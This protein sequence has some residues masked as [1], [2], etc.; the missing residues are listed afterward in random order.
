MRLAVPLAAL[1]GLA[2]FVSP[3]TARPV[4]GN[5]LQA[6][7][8]ADLESGRID[9]ETWLIQSFRYV[10]APERLAAH[11]APETRTLVR[12][13]TP[14]IVEYERAR[15]ELSAAAIAEIESYL[16]APSATLRASYISPA[17]LFSLTYDTAGANAVNA[18]DVA[19]ANGVPDYVERCATYMDES[20]AEEITTLGFTAPALPGDG[21]YDV[22]FESMGAYG[23]TTTSGITTRI[24]LHNTF[25]GFPPNTDP[26]GNQLGAA[27]VTCAHEFKHASQFTTSGWSEGGWVELDAT[28]AEDI[29]YPATNDYWNYTNTN[30][31][32]VLGQPWTPLDDG[33]S[34]SYE[35]CLW[36]TYLSS[37]HGNALVVDFWDLRDLNPG[38]TVKKTYGDA[39]AL[40]GTNWDDSYAGFLEWSWFTGSRSEP[41]FGFPDAPNLKRMNLRGAAVAA[42]PFA[43]ADSVNQLAGHP[44]RFNPGTATG[45]PRVQFDGV[46]AHTNFTVS[47]ILKELAGAFTI[48]R[49]PVGAGNV[50]DYTSPLPWSALEYVGVIVANTK[51]SGGNQH[52]DLDVLDEP[53][54][55]AAPLVASLPDRLRQ[56]VPAPNP[57]AG[58]TTLRFALPRAGRATVRILD[59]AGRVIRTLVDG[60]RPAGANE[61]RWDGRDAAGRPVAAGIY[62]SRVEFGAERNHEKITLLR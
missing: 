36:E 14:V 38:D 43:V 45:A 28:W 61:V 5:S 16:A 6:A 23:Y 32:S 62:W 50:V 13:F 3:V 39:L 20:W 53:T 21:T 47:V 56:D 42:Y 40:Y 18:T 12:C 51:R 58:A 60:S 55:V 7:L 22:A 15:P 30:G 35:D 46:D 27:K 52:Y 54:A 26:D 10:F 29:V 37:L 31:A 59:V 19:P 9:R 8:V 44:W 4:D 24:V 49:P 48:V 33:G 34:G 1:A 2:V 41:A 17:G 57:T 11:Y 25:L